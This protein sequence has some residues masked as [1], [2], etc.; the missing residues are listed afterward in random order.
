M[1]EVSNANKQ[2]LA[3]GHQVNF[4]TTAGKTAATVTTQS[5][6]QAGGGGTLHQRTGSQLASHSNQLVFMD[7]SMVN[8]QSLNRKASIDSKVGGTAAVS[9][10]IK[11]ADT[12]SHVHGH[13]TAAGGEEGSHGQQ[14]RSKAQYDN[15]LQLQVMKK[16]TGAQGVATANTRSQSSN[17]HSKGTR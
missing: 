3:V 5:S 8:Y 4:A 2:N 6:K 11:S 15:W 12:H 16:A 13:G 14:M 1:L 17:M 9:G 10:V 7:A